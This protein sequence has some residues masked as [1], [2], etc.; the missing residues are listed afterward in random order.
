MYGANLGKYPYETECSKVCDPD[1]VYDSTNNVL[2][3]YWSAADDTKNNKYHLLWHSYS[4]NGK[5]WE[6]PLGSPGSGKQY[7]PCS[8]KEADGTTDY[9]FTDHLSPSVIKDGSTWKM[10][11]VDASITGHPVQYFESTDTNHVVWIRKQT[12]TGMISDG[13]EPWHIEVQKVGNEYWGFIVE[14]NYDVGDQ[15]S[16]S[17]Y[18]IKSSDGKNWISYNSPVLPPTSSTSGKWDS[19]FTYRSTFAVESGL[20]RVWYS[21]CKYIRSGV[22]YYRIGYTWLG[23]F[24]L[25]LKSDNV[26]G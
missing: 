2:H 7:E 17:V 13:R 11:S 12:C 14:Q 15:T 10:W 4:Y 20:L 18:F 26:I 5:D 24:D 1:L 16:C 19:A 23:G 8:V 3:A 9:D 21:A 22:Y 25:S 6:V